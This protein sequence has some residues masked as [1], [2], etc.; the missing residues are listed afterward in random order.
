[1]GLS[2]GWFDVYA[3]N[4]PGQELDIRGVRDGRFCLKMTADPGD[5][6][7]EANETDNTRSTI[8]RIVGPNGDRPRSPLPGRAALGVSGGNRAP[9]RTGP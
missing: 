1:M 7:L 5:R 8:L 3:A 9:G 4:L 2:V 6:V